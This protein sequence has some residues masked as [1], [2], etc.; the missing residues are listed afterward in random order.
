MI[1]KII[2]ENIGESQTEPKPGL[3]YAVRQAEIIQKF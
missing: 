1:K 3:S 2:N